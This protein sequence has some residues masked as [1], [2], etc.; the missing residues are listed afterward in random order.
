MFR[1]T[2]DAEAVAYQIQSNHQ[3][4]RFFDKTYHKN[5]CE[6][7]ILE[8]RQSKYRNEPLP[9]CLPNESVGR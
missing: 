3:V 9:W 7:L 5:K 6:S 1:D 8:N 2:R 4:K